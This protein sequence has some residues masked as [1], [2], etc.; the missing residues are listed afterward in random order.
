MRGSVGIPLVIAE[1]G[2]LSN[3]ENVP[4]TQKEVLPVVL[5]CVVWGHHWKSKRVQLY[6]DNE[7]AVAVLNAGYSH[8]SLIMHLLRA[9]FF[10]KAHF[11][12][13]VRVTHILELHRYDFLNQAR[14]WFLKITSVRMYVCVCLCV[15]VCVCSPPRP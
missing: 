1:M 7:A 14:T 9:L 10:M 6:C 5:A 13:D 3:L 2:Q 8:D 15:S 11:D 4:I 12:L